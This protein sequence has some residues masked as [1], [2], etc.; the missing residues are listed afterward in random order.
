MDPNVDNMTL[1]SVFG[2]SLNR[3]GFIDKAASYVTLGETSR[4]GVYVAGA[5]TGPETIDDSIAQG[6]AAALAALT[7]AGTRQV[8]AAE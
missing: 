7:R 5:A 1:A 8:R 3:Y 6:Q 2:V 4:P